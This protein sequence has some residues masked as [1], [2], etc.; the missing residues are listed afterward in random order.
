MKKRF[1]R[2]TQDKLLV[3]LEQK[4]ANSTGFRDSKLSTERK[5]VLDYYHGRLPRPH[6]SGNSKYVSMDVYDTVESMKA[7]LLETFASGAGIIE[8]TPQGSQD[9]AGAKVATQFTDYVVF[10]RNDGYSIFSDVIQDALL[11]RVGVAKVYWEKAEELVDEEFTNI[12]LDEMDAILAAPDVE[13]LVEYW[14]EDPTIG[15]LSGRIT[16]KKKTSGVRIVVIP[17]EELRVESQA[18]CLKDAFHSHVT[19]KTIAELIRDGFNAEKVRKLS[20]V[21][22]KETDPEVL[23]RFES[24]SDMGMDPEEYQEQVTR[25]TVYE[26]YIRVDMTGN[27]RT[28]LYKVIHGDKVI[29]DMEEVERSPFITYVPLPVPHSFW[30]NNFGKLVTPIQNART[31]LMRSI[32]DHAVVTNNPRYMV[33]K[34]ALANPRELLDNRVGGLVNVSRPDG[35]VPM[36]QAGLNPFVFQSIQLLDEDKEDT[37][38]IS[39]LSQGL[40]KDAVS[41]QNSGAMV[42]QLVTLSQQRQKIMARNFAMQFLVPLFLEVYRLVLENAEE[43]GQQ[44][45]DVAG[46]F[47]T[48]D[49]TAW[50]ER[51]D[52]SVSLRLGYG[53]KEREAQKHMMLHQMLSADPTIAPLY[54]IEEKRKNLAKVLEHSEIKDVDNY[55]RPLEK[56]EQPQPDPM[57]M[58]ELEQMK[59]SIEVMRRQQELAE[60]KQQSADHLAQMKLEFEKMKAFLEN[61]H[62]TLEA[63]RKQ[64]ETDSKVDIAAREM[65]LAESAPEQNTIISPNA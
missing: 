62:K 6:H 10:R 54:T 39:R 22:D 33:V 5:E 53:E 60:V 59:A 58:A 65:D 28:K 31:V 11:A 42:E 8:F 30:G 34:G 61:T 27:G 24:L 32:L 14:D 2:M 3:V 26:S 51:T 17:P 56:V 40:N 16:R 52:V 55:L 41:K 29:L 13:E 15:T 50:E 57:M 19:E 20:K 9:V 4:V 63:D 49:P 46:E 35:I 25:V 36:P 21:E 1:E 43:V 37:T 7:A 64:Q 38:G 12:S 18:K 48:I 47:I 44:V 45:I 23:A